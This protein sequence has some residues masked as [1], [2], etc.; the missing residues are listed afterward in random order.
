MKH[1]PGHL[2]ITCM[3]LFSILKRAAMDECDFSRDER[4]LFT[5]C[6]FWAA[7]SA[8]ELRTHLGSRPAE[9]LRTAG[10]SLTSVGAV[11]LAQ[12]VF[13]GI[14]ELRNMTTADR[15]DEYIAKLEHQLQLTEDSVDV[16]IGLM[17]QR[18]L[19]VGTPIRQAAVNAHIN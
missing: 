13:A 10:I 4:V 16:L 1:W 18:C 3:A 6:E 14:D 15:R 19:S 2:P 12:V 9:R 8:S 5:T 17:A 11:G 7:V